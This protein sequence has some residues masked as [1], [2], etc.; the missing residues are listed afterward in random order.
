LFAARAAIR[1]PGLATGPA[2]LSRRS[3]HIAAIDGHIVR[4]ATH[5]I[6]AG[7]EGSASPDVDGGLGQ[8]RKRMVRGEED[9]LP[10]RDGTVLGTQ[11]VLHSLVDVPRFLSV[12]LRRD[13]DEAIFLGIAEVGPKGRT[14]G[15][16]SFVEGL[17]DPAAILVIRIHQNLWIHRITPCRGSEMAVMR[18]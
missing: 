17:E 4:S 12:Y 1:A 7:A 2:N 5:E 16:A 18:L 13:E 15:E 3:V 14:D 10:Q 6:R 9:D 8:L 11:S